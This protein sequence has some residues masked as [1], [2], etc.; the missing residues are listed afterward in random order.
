M[1]CSDVRRYLSE[2][3]DGE[4]DKLQPEEQL[5]TEGPVAAPPLRRDIDTHLESC[6]DCRRELHLLTKTI[7]ALRALP[8][9]SLPADV[10]LQIDRGLE[11]EMLAAAASTRVPS[12]T[13]EAPLPASTTHSRWAYALP[14]AA[15]VLIVAALALY[16]HFSSIPSRDMAGEDLARRTETRIAEDAKAERDEALEPLKSKED[17]PP[18]GP[19][20][21][22]AA[23]AGEGVY[24]NGSAGDKS[25]LRTTEPRQLGLTPRQSVEAGRSDS[26]FEEMPEKGLP[27]EAAGFEL[28][29]KERGAAPLPAL[30]LN[31]AVI[32]PAKADQEL[33]AILAKNNW[34]NNLR[35]VD[36]V[37]TVEIPAAEVSRLVNKLNEAKSFK[38]VPAAQYAY[39][40]LPESSDSIV[41]ESQDA[42]APGTETAPPMRSLQEVETNGVGAALQSDRLEAR[43]HAITVLTAEREKPSGERVPA[44]QLSAQAEGPVSP[45]ADW[46]T[47]ASPS[48]EPIMARTLAPATGSSLADLRRYAGLVVVNI[49][50]GRPA[51]QRPQTQPAAAPTRQQAQ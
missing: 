2:Y 24:F 46:G 12:G 28:L 45:A 7:D 35:R 4:L 22:P 50:L 26:L 49:V 25:G 13:A 11:R 16:F 29:L 44:V 6:E 39:D 8:K 17:S 5:P 9:R 30:T 27:P 47:A 33:Q 23:T 41:R 42:A 40:L 38:P 14:A 51:Q 1:E 43:E 21:S 18:G 20:A 36:N 37:Y 48:G 31:N 3:L 34:T 32:V 15:S 10:R 19:S